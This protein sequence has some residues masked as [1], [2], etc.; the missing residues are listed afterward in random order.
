MKPQWLWMGS[1]RDDGFDQD[2]AESKR[3]ERAVILRLQSSSVMAVSV[4]GPLKNRL[5]MS[6]RKSDLMVW[7][8]P[9][10]AASCARSSVVSGLSR[11]GGRPMSETTTIGLDIAKHVFQVHG[12]AADGTVTVKRRL[13]RSEVIRFFDR[14]PRC[15]V[16][17]EACGGAH[18][19]AREITAL[20]HDVRLIPAAYVKPYVKRGKTDAIDAEAIC[21]AVSRPTMR[22]VAIKTVNYQA[23]VM[24]LNTRRLLVKQRTQAINSLRGHLGELGII[25]AKGAGKV[26]TLISIIRDKTDERLPAVARMA[27]EML[28]DQ[29]E[30]LTQRIAALDTRSLPRFGAM[31][32]CA[33][34][35]VSWRR[36]DHRSNDCRLGPRSQSI[37]LCPAFCRVDRP[38]TKMHSTGGKDLGEDL[39][40]GKPRV[41]IFAGGWRDRDMCT[42]AS[43]RN[44][45]TLVDWP[46]GASTR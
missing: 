43:W 8:D 19:W 29:I 45:I 32:R 36:S 41:A 42:C 5:P 23:G 10:L 20:G 14:L 9:A 6:Q 16:G 4:I 11:R 3:D 28:A 22:F 7:N 37:Y 1:R 39:K 38:D 15:R 26:E 2:E 33:T 44:S 27:L 21:E 34:G 17:L 24:L 35:Y 25:A 40:N 46:I 12:V 13:R 18:F 30:G 31:T